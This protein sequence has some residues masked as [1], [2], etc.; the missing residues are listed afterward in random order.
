MAVV[1]GLVL[2][3]SIWLFVLRGYDRIEPDAL[4]YL[5]R[6][7]V[8]G[9]L[10]S[11]VA[12]TLLNE[13]YRM[14]LGI[15]DTFILAPEQVPL[16]KIMFFALL[17][18]MSEEICK[19]VAAVYATRLFG[20][21]DEP[22]DAMIYAMSVALGF[23]TVE[24]LLY[25]LQFG[26]DVLVWRFLWPVPAHMAYAAVWGYGFAQARFL[27]P[28][29]NRARMMAPSVAMAGL[30]HAAGNLGLF[31]DQAFTAILSLSVLAGLG[32]L[33][34]LRLMK[35]VTE[36]PF[37]EPGECPMC[38]NLNHA[39]ASHC[40]F[41]GTP[42]NDTEFYR[43]CPC[44]KKRIPAHSRSCVHCGIPISTPS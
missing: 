37:L 22:I 25:A 36:S 5:L 8:L 32:Y 16:Q 27:Y 2:G 38:R 31:L 4:R 20:E 6:V 29:R 15:P 34:H 26:P 39:G 30:L 19:A 3:F 40:F 21:I 18:G 10:A 13:G 33:A 1:A 35:L 11:L 17:A 41:C 44:G 23:A 14:A 9:G 24:N 43:L 28:N 42:L 12:A 7:A